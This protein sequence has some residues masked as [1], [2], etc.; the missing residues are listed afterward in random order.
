MTL[1]IFLQLAGMFL[2]PMFI[3]L[4]P[5]LIGQ[6]YGKYLRRKSEKLKK[7][8]IEPVVGAAFALLAFMLAITFQ[9]VSDRWDTRKTL[10]LEEVTNIRTAYLRAGL[11]KEP[12][13]SEA[14][15]QLV[16]YIDLRFEFAHD[17]KKLEKLISGSSQI[18]DTLWS[19]TET[20]AEEDRSS[21]VYALFTQS[22]NDLI[23]NYNHRIT[24]SLQYR[25]P[26][27]ILWVLGIITFVSMFTF[28]I[29]LGISGKGNFWI[30]LL[31]SLIFAVVMFLI[32]ALDRPETGLARLNQKPVI[33][34]HEQLHK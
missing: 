32:L 22:I 33:S 4:I 14:K 15:K 2:I 19:Y 17:G 16:E 8:S 20:L 25:L 28:G 11:L 10:L 1:K 13:R 31:L 24:M 5:I 9:I 7:I 27:A 34:L 3:I 21:E 12:I 29:Q 23:D 26:A 30:S 18:L 6:F